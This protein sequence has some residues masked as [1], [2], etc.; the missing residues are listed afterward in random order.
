MT[1]WNALVEQ[2]G[3]KPGDTVLV[4]GTGGVSIF[5]LQFARLAGARVIATSSSD[6]KL[7]RAR[8][9]GA[10]RRHQLQDDP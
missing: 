10:A 2:C 4:Q 5:A 8:E 1:A 3:V 7:A 6:Q 9:L